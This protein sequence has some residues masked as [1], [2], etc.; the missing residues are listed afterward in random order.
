MTKLNLLY[1]IPNCPV[2][3]S[4]AK[5]LRAIRPQDQNVVGKI[6]DQK[7]ADELLEKYPQMACFTCLY[8]IRVPFLVSEGELVGGYDD[9]IRHFSS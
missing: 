1:V 5:K 3:Q 8:G 9:M 2:C 7:G 6:M 4:A